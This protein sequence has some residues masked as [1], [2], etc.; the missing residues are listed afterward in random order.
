MYSKLFQTCLVFW[1]VFF[2][3]A[4]A[5]SIQTA[6]FSYVTVE[7]ATLCRLS[8]VVFAVPRPIITWEVNGSLITQGLEETVVSSS[9][10]LYRSRLCLVNVTVASSGTYSCLAENLVGST[11]AN[12]N[13]T[14][15]SMSWP[16]LL[17]VILSKVVRHWHSCSF[18]L[19]VQG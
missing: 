19:C 12:A 9:A 5:P 17:C 2:L 13:V 6:P 18:M 16:L 3:F 10:A 8:C 14:V 7:N 15:T 11:S 4:V 1:L